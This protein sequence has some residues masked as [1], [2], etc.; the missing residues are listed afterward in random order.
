M[1]SRTISLGTFGY[2]EVRFD[3]FVDSMC[4]SNVRRYFFVDNLHNEFYAIFPGNI[5]GFFF[6]NF[7]WSLVLTPF[8][9]RYVLPDSLY[10]PLVQTLVSFCSLES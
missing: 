8:W 9:I 2:D 7:K 3:T 10:S 4:R 1:L 5:C 6:F